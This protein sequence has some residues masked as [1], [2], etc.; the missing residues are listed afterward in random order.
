MEILSRLKI[1]KVFD[2]RTPGFK[3][4]GM[5]ASFNW[6][7]RLEVKRPTITMA[8]GKTLALESCFSSKKT[9]KLRISVEK[10]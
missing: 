7:K 1:V 5:L 10:C 3:R 8:I 2:G 9:R 6:I 4:E